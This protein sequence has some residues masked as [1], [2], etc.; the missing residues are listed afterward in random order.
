MKTGRS[1]GPFFLLGG[2][3]ASGRAGALGGRRTQ[4]LW[5]TLRD[6]VLSLRRAVAHPC[7]TWAIALGY[8]NLRQ[9]AGHGSD[10][11]GHAWRLHAIA[12]QQSRHTD[13]AMDAEPHRY[14]GCRTTQG[15]DRSHVP[16]APKDA[17]LSPW[18]SSGTRMCRGRELR[19]DAGASDDPH[20]GR[21]AAPS[22]AHATRSSCF[23]FGSGFRSTSARACRRRP[24]VRPGAG[25]PDA[26]A[27][28]IGTR[29][30][31]VF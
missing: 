25:G 2:A 21:A 16:N 17:A 31:P 30:Q 5:P 11:K 22:E 10:R 4:G 6:D 13:T 9:R 7:A 20:G 15:D 19:Q 27:D 29:R 14:A 3:W 12:D 24:S 18:G 23:G 28:R 1:R 8:G 26:K